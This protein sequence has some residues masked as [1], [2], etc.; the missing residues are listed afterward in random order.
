[1]YSVRFDDKTKSFNFRDVAEVNVQLDFLHSISRPPLL[2]EIR[3]PR[4]VIRLGVRID[5]SFVILSNAT[6]DDRCFAA[7][8]GDSTQHGFLTLLGYGGHSEVPREYLV[9][10]PVVRHAVDHFIATK[11]LSREVTWVQYSGGLSNGS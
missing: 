4:Y 8:Y 9:P 5:P 10:M 11:Q 2:V 1:M 6:H 7:T 3:I